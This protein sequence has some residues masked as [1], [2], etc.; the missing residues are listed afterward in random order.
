[1]EWL[2][3]IPF[4]LIGAVFALLTRPL[5]RFNGWT[6]RGIYGLLLGHEEWID[7]VT[8]EDGRPRPEAEVSDRRRI[9]YW[10][11]TAPVVVY[12]FRSIGL[13]AVVIGVGV[14][15]NA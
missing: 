2:G 10:P 12:L 11:D 13:L 1:M 8:D 4:V 15:V 3:G 6:C 9:L 5:L 14:I 7:S